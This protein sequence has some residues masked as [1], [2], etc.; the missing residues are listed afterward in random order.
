MRKVCLFAIA[1]LGLLAGGSLAVRV[2]FPPPVAFHGHTEPV[3]AVIASADGKTLASLSDKDQT[4]KL[5][6]LAT[7]KE[8]ATLRGNEV[9]LSPDGKILA[10]A[11]YSEGEI[12]LWDVTNSNHLAT[13]RGHAGPI[14][15][16]AFSPDGKTLASG[17][18]DKTTKLWDVA[19]ARERATLRHSDM[20][21][22]VAF[23]PDGKTLATGSSG[24]TVRLWDITPD[25]E[26]ARPRT[27]EGGA[28]QQGGCVISVAFSPD[29]RTLASGRAEKVKLWDV[30]TGQGRGILS[31]QPNHD[32]DRIVFSPDSRAL[33][34][35]DTYSMISLWETATG[36]RTAVPEKR[37]SRPRP[38]LLRYAWD[39][40]PDIFQEY[41]YVPSSIRFTQDGTLMAMGYDNRD[42]T[43]ARM[44]QVSS[45]PVMKK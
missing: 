15:A 34:A 27:L 18:Y 33:A 39:A 7:Q 3:T 20:V 25:K 30:R 10:F 37:Y 23:S 31:A 5:W 2:V 36:T 44:W 1:F 14:E 4:I 28:I 13:M 19:T 21:L 26:L 38:R 9:A 29:G 43:T 12:Q 11:K 32:I 8:L 45:V 22:S 17:S 41:M 40:F 6:D 42:V 35:L 16:L 24:W